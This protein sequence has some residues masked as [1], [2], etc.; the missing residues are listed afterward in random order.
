S[1]DPPPPSATLFPYTTLFRSDELLPASLHQLGDPIQDLAPIECGLACPVGDRLARGPH[2]IADVLARRAARIGEQPATCVEDLVG[3]TGLGARE[4]P[5]DVQLVGLAHLEPVGEAALPV[6]GRQG[7]GGSPLQDRCPPARPPRR[8]GCGA[9][10][11]GAAA[12]GCPAS[13][14]YWSVSGRSRR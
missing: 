1:T 7:G 4:L 5:A 12:H 3:A 11:R 14:P 6:G 2:G 10:R 9:A 13:V 8:R